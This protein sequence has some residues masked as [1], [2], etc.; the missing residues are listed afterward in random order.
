MEILWVELKNP[1]LAASEWDWQIDA[2]R[3]RWTLINVYDRY[4]IPILI[5]ENGLGAFDKV[6]RW[7]YP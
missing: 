6:K 3:L 4:R 7:K 2:K 5:S 1:Y